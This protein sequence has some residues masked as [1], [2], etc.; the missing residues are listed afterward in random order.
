MKKINQKW[1]MAL[2]IFVSIPR[3]FAFGVAELSAVQDYGSLITLDEAI[4]RTLEN[5]ARIKEAIERLEKEKSLYKSKRAEFFPKISTE[6]FQA[7]ATGQK[8]N[9]TYFDIAITQS[10]FEGGKVLAEK[11]KQET[12][13]KEGE[14]QLEEAKLDLRQAIKILYT[15]ALQE[16]ELTRLSQLQVK[17]LQKY[18]KAMA[19]LF[20]KELLTRYELLKADSAL[21]KTKHMLLKHKETYDY[22]SEFLKELLG[23]D[24]NETLELEMLK[25]VPEL[26]D[27]VSGYF[28]LAHAN[29]PFYEITELKVKEKGFEKRSLEADRY[30]HLG[31]AVRSDVSRDIFVDTN[32]LMLGASVKW[33]VWDFGRL[34][35]QIKAKSHEIE[36][37]RWQSKAEIQ[38][39]DRRIRKLFHEAR[40]FREKIRLSETLVQ[41]REEA[42]K[43]DKVRII[44]GDRGPQEA[45]ESFLALQEAYASQVKAITDYRIIY[46]KLQRQSAAGH[47]TS[48]GVSV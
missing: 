41:E 19:A 40:T 6:L 39:K 33:D 26:Q 34:G 15:E 27:D 29:D 14:L 22:L 44:A 38:E 37:T 2:L 16:K 17:E 11:R 48:S 4:S 42:Y 7:V 3:G 12:R 25:D 5:H 21:E 1:I 10:L 47:A 46:T 18:H 31:L 8:K 9:V 43:N 23:M 30:P 36:E 24:Q 13:V 35:N 32:R 20:E 28:K 45:L